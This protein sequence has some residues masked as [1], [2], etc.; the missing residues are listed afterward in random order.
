MK[1]FSIHD[2]RNLCGI[3]IRQERIK[4]DMSQQ[5]LASSMNFYGLDISH[6]MI[7]RIELGKRIITDYELYIISRV[8]EISINHFFSEVDKLSKEEL[9]VFKFVPWE[10]NKNDDM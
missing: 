2:N 3:V 1:F 10:N 9:S 8:F 6:K 4:R 5:E 7:S